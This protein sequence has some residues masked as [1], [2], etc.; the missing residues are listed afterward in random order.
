[1]SVT[2]KIRLGEGAAAVAFAS[3]RSIANRCGGLDHLGYA[4]MP[5]ARRAARIPALLRARGT[6]EIS[7]Y[8]PDE[9]DWPGLDG[10]DLTRL[11]DVRE[12]DGVLFHCRSTGTGGE[13]IH[14]LQ[15]FMKN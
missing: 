8:L 3:V 10:L 2:F 4:A 15:L 1:M 11:D 14:V 13:T 5:S 7:F 12:L 6:G 9:A